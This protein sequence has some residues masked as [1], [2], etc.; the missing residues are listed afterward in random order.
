MIVSN[1]EFH[2]LVVNIYEAAAEP[3]KWPQLAAAIAESVERSAYKDLENQPDKL[4]GNISSPHQSSQLASLQKTLHQISPLTLP[5]D[6]E[7]VD[8]SQPEFDAI[9]LRYFQS[10]IGIAQKLNAQEAYR[11]VM[12]SV[13]DQL[14]IA[15]MIITR[16][17]EIL[18]SNVLA[19]E[20]QHSESLLAVREGKVDIRDSDSR[21]NLFRA[22]RNVA[23]GVSESSSEVLMLGSQ[24]HPLDKLMVLLSAIQGA[25]DEGGAQ[26]IALFLSS[27][28][29]QPVSIPLSIAKYYG[30]TRKESEVASYLVRGFSVKEIAD[31]IFVSEH[32]VRSHLKA[33][34]TKTET[35][36]Q[37]ELVRMLLV[38]PT[39]LF[40]EVTRFA[41]DKERFNTQGLKKFLV[42]KERVIAYREYGPADG[43]P[44]LYLHC[45]IGSGNELEMML[46]EAEMQELGFRIIAPDRPGYGKS[47]MSKSISF[48][49]FAHDLNRL[50]DHLGIRS[51]SIL[52]FSMGAL[53]GCALGVY[54]PGRVNKIVAV[55]AGLASTEKEEFDQMN[56]LWRMSNLMARDIPKAY[57]IIANLMF[58]AIRKNPEKVY[59]LIATDTVGR[60]AELFANECFKQRYCQ[61]LEYSLQQ[62][63]YAL[64]REVEQLM[65]ELNFDPSEIAA[66]VV[67][68]HGSSDMHVPISVARRFEQRLLNVEFRV[69]HGA[70]HFF[71]FYK[72]REILE[73]EFK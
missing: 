4:Y 54:Y 73:L 24:S 49:A 45:V 1:K 68:W 29:N 35:Q 14:P 39:P 36:R 57:R 50:L 63:L 60:E 13:L 10:A 46:S 43:P 23:A 21:A 58:I 19:T 52:G 22:I 56:S 2:A 12:S 5:S 62:G 53:Y 47:S 18:E 37:T 71:I 48:E 20:M 8:Y 17:G 69:E 66:P 72:L 9:L 51:V 41:S 61:Y 38:G 55:S 15:L 28:R 59:E 32:T 3:D 65:R 33:L 67:L 31:E 42:D 26:N 70:S 44:L 64:C 11:Q 25:N 34:L 27:P 30:L 16:E 7:V 40:D 6:Q